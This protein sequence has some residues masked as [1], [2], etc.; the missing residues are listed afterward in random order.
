MEFSGFQFHEIKITILKLKFKE[1]KELKKAEE[2]LEKNYQIEKKNEIK[3]LSKKE[4][5]NAK[6]DNKIA[7][8]I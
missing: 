2:N 6:K 4:Q 7:V 8:Q 5:T 1:T 3:A